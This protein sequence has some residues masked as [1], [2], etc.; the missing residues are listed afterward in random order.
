[1]DLLNL[2]TRYENQMRSRFSFK[3][4]IGFNLIDFSSPAKWLAFQDSI[5]FP[6]RRIFSGEEEN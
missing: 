6:V 1:M 2:R 4:P 3:F 5:F